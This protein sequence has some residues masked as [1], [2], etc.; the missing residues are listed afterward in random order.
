MSIQE[1]AS[2]DIGSEDL[3]FLNAPAHDMVESTRCIQPWLFRLDVPE[4]NEGMLSSCLRTYPFVPTAR[5]KSGQYVLG[6]DRSQNI[7]MG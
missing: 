7:K 2:F 6:G 1:I 3:G 4:P 5:E